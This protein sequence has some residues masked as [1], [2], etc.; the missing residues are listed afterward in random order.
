MA[1]MV[2]RRSVVKKVE[3]TVSSGE[4]TKVPSEIIKLVETLK[5]RRASKVISAACH[6]CKHD[7]HNKI[8]YT[9]SYEYTN[10]SNAIRYG[11]IG[12]FGPNS[13]NSYKK[14][15]EIKLDL[16]SEVSTGSV[17]RETIRNKVLAKGYKSYIY[18]DEFIVYLNTF[19]I[20]NTEY[21]IN[22][23]QKLVVQKRFND[24]S[25]TR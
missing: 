15:S 20:S 11:V 13:D 2:V 22:S 10:Y 25:K 4:F 6:I 3:N 16:T 8:Y 1:Q 9:I 19:I 24:I 21:K 17:F 12:F 23:E 7:N 5:E 14:V 18:D